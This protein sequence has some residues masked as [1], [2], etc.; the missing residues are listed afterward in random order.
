MTS[1]KNTSLYLAFRGQMPSSSVNAS[2]SPRQNWFSNSARS[3]GAF[4]WD[5][6]TFRANTRPG[7]AAQQH[8]IGLVCSK[9][10][11]S[12]LAPKLTG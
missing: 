11:V 3:S 10:L 1:L 9:S 7:G 12:L 2:F 5:T 4:L 8:D 6:G